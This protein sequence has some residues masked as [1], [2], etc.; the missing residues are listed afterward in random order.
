MKKILTLIIA[1]LLAGAAVASSVALKP[2][3]PQRYVVVKGD[4][5]WDIAAKFL[6][7]PWQWPNIWYAN[8]QVKN[9]HLIYPGDTLTLVWVNGKPQIR[10]RRGRPTIKLSPHARAIPL[11]KAIPTIPL[12]AIGPF[13]NRTR[14]VGKD[15]L[16]KSPYIVSHAD[17]RV[18]A[19]AN[20]RVYVRGIKV[21]HGQ[22]AVVRK[23]DVYTDPVTKEVL[24]Y[25]ATY[26]GTASLER[27]G[28]PATLRLL[29]TT[30][31]ALMGDRLLASSGQDF[32]TNF[33]PHAPRK[34]VNGQIISV[35]DGVSQIGQHQVVVINRGKR[36]GMEVGHVLAV[37]QKGE[38]VPDLVTPNRKDKVKLPDE[39]AGLLMVFRTF[40][41]VSYALVMRATRAMHV[42]DYV[43]NP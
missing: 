12:S 3:H 35:V 36:E 5:L 27:P 42:Y 22:Y 8:P 34:K 28:D 37:Y 2:G 10:I 1:A 17:N 4:T 25:E 41:K 14:V 7:N 32:N 29:D 30:R 39:R 26:I 38:T 43:R 31:E 18:I 19:G 24:G 40:D 21:S 33:M 11:D 15:E 16:E 9:P 13:L 23:G 20:Q 6:K